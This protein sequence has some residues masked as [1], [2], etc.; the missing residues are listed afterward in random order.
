METFEVGKMK[1]IIKDGKKTGKKEYMKVG[2]GRVVKGRE[3]LTCPQRN[4]QFVA[5]AGDYVISLPDYKMKEQFKKSKDGEVMETIR[6]G[7]VYVVNA[8]MFDMSYVRKTSDEPKGED[9]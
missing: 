2:T 1:D 7:Q 4:V 9:A 3:Y 5:D 8:T 6:K